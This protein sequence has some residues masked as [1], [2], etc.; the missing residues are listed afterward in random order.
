MLKTMRS[1]EVSRVVSV[2]HTFPIFVAIMAVPLL[3]EV[4][5]KTEWLAIFMT[6]TGRTLYRT[7]LPR[8]SHNHS[9]G[10][11]S[12]MPPATFAVRLTT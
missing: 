6:V 9:L 1:E 11:S 5:G 12:L 3:G 4:L 7:S 8:D 10:T 2:V